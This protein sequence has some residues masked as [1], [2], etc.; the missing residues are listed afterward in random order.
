VDNKIKNIFHNN[1]QLLNLLEKVIYYFHIQNYD[2]ALRNATE[3]INVFS[4][5]LEL[6]FSE[7]IYFNNN[8]KLI[9][10]QEVVK[11]LNSLLEAQENQDYILLSDLYEIQFIPFL[12]NL[13]EA[14][15]NREDIFQEE[16]YLDTLNILKQA[17]C[18]FIADL[19]ELPEPI[20]LLEYGYSIEPTSSGLMT[21]AITSNE[22]KYYMH[23]N[24]NASTEAFYLA[25][26][27]YKEDKQIYIIYGFG[28]GY[29]IN[30]LSRLDNNIRIEI[31][32]SDLNIIK[33]ACAYSDIK[34]IIA[35]ANVRL[36]YDPDFL[37]LID[38][39]SNIKD[40]T[41]FVLHYPSLRHIQNQ[42]IREELYDYF[43]QYS[44]IKNQLHILNGN[45]YENILHY[46]AVV[47][48]LYQE[49]KD[50]ELFIIAAG[51]S[52][53]KNFMKLKNINKETSIILATGT[54]VRKLINAGICPDY[55]I[56]TDASYRVFGQINGVDISSI[57]L[58]FISTAYLGLAK[59]HRGK[60]Y[61]IYQKNYIKAEEMAKKLS[62][63]T[64]NTGGSV[65]T[66]ALDIG[67]AFGC[68]RIIFLGLDLAYTD[69]FIHATDTSLRELS[70]TADLRQIEDINGNM[71]YTSKSLDMYRKWIE[72][73]IRGVEGIEFIDASEGGA[74]IEGMKIMQLSDC[75]ST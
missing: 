32:E 20:E 69:H 11:M 45:F 68:K 47:D 51:P 10:P 19:Y 29:H 15:M 58:L 37:K 4:S 27:W 12:V 52:L 57:P 18:D 63:H 31:Y 75:I 55:I 6:L 28:M 7:T 9:N 60:R 70:D 50:K 8:I 25:Q 33:L 40:E 49:F 38:R 3:I 39:L 53:D 14:I 54:V 26:S 22:K 30:E 41:E 44:S 48:D 71:I 1:I 35:N 67:I 42:A 36:I 72:N 17:N 34:D 43:I 13:Q 65:S 59:N 73:R 5:Y 62:I 2:S 64:Y 16:K 56:M 24:R 66:T 21:L 61:I 74:R 46:D 23:S